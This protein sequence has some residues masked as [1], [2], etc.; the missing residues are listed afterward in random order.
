MS[1]PPDKLTTEIAVLGSGP[2]GSIMAALLAEA[3]REVL[4]IED[5]PLVPPDEVPQFSRAEMVRKYRN[6]GLTVAM[7][8][9]KVAYVEARC[10]G[11]GSEINSGLYHRT[12]LEILDQWRRDFAIEHLSADDLQESFEANERELSVSYLPVPAPA[13]SQRLSDGASSLGWHALEVPRWHKYPATEIPSSGERQT[14]TRTF[15]RRATDAGAR[16]LAGHRARRLRRSKTGWLID[17]AVRNAQGA[18]RMATIHAQTAILACGAIQTP[19]ILRHSGIGRHAGEVLHM[20]PTVKVVAQ[21]PDRVNDERLG[22]GVHQVKPPGAQL[23]LGCSV[24]TPPHLAVALLPHR[25]SVP[26]LARQWQQMAVYYCASTGGRGTVQTIPC[27][28]DPLVRYHLN[29]DNLSELAGGLRDL[30]RCLFAAG[31]T[32]LYPCLGGAPVLSN[33]GEL[34]LLPG[35]L[36]AAAANLMTV[37]LFSS[38][39]LGENRDRCTADSFGRVHGEQNLWIADA[40]LLPGPPGVNPQGTIMAIVRRNAR[41]LLGHL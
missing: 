1:S 3:G 6:G 26:N 30:C 15:L 25:Q 13:A 31:A 16:L 9:A 21:F 24:S 33:E 7:G 36:P 19:A 39:P 8:R 5:G 20:H 35:C 29:D 23:S 34:D 38:C 2:G 41:F 12:P 22:V 37:H 28:R 27:Y 11:G 14:M 17:V 10:V 32:A 40:S 18:D 4:L